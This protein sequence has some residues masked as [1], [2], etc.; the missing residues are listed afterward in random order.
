MILP[1]PN[2]L[3]TAALRY[4][5]LGHPVFPCVPGGSN[6]LTAHGFH[7]ATVDA[8]Q[9]DRWWT[10]HPQANIGLPTAGLIVL[11]IDGATNP[12]P[13][14]DRALDL[15][16]APMAA[17]PRGGSHRVFRQPAGKAWR[18]TQSALAPQVDTRAAGGYIVAPPSRRSDGEYRWVPGL[19]LDVPPDRL[20]E[21]PPWLVAQ[22]DRLAANAPRSCQA[23]GSPTIAHVAA[24]ADE[25][26]KIPSG[27]RNAT[28]ARLGGAMRRVGMSQPEIAAALVRANADRCVPPLAPREV[29]RIA[30]SIARYEPDQIAVA[31]A[32]NHWDQMYVDRVDEDVGG[33][34]DPGPIPPHLLRVPGFIDAV[35]DYTLNTAPYPEPV[36]AFCGALALQA[37]L[38]GRKVRDP[39]DNR[40]NLYVL[41]LANSGAGKDYPRKVNQKI[42]LE[43]G[44]SDGLG[45]TF[46]SGEGIEDRIFTHPAVLFQTDEIDGLMSKINLGKDA[47]HE[48]IMNVLLKMYT[49]ANSLYPMRVKAGKEHGVIDQPCLCIFGTAIPKHYY[50]AL[51]LKMLTN[52][53]FARMLILETG[54]RGVGQDAHVR[55]LPPGV[56]ATAKWWA[57]F[58]PGEKH[59]NLA[60][61]HP[62][63]AV[64]DHSLE[65]ADVLRAFRDH[66][67]RE[68][69]AA[70]DRN[71][72][73]G[74][75][76]WARANEKARRLA[77]VYAC[78]RDHLHLEIT[79]DAA[80]WA[81]EFVDHQTR[82]ML[83]MAGESVSENEFDG[84]CKKLVATLRSWRAKH[85]DEWMPFWKIN[86]KHPWS[87]R[88]HEEVRTT[89]LNQRLIEYDERR[90][91]GTPQRLYR[92]A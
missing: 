45:D 62:V 70:E 20:P 86:R 66:A 92:L 59:G 9:I 65:A 64:I 15:A 73:V 22:L 60:D 4:A 72:P 90:T 3:H 1:P 27:Q 19:E 84:R 89:L 69:G 48:G 43:A 2:P 21:P 81:C 47:R 36:L 51:S 29:D 63:P 54:K 82:R 83:F 40:T 57:E 34:D 12:W 31:L 26:N 18:C 28:L 77:L 50:E 14:A 37:L 68:Y 25:A 61:W 23:T 44:L 32:E 75:A 5:E 17:T 49:S 76:I 56:V 8:D 7:D 30:A 80:R 10:A 88:E 55:P 46:A 35:I 24:G 79:R 71:D 33:E 58:S 67:D 13:G 53:F 87:E 52:G 38:S 39:A 16:A 42:L 6:P 74:M 11:D 41:G 85:G 91:G 78:S